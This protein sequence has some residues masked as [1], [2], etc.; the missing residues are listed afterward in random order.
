MAR[1]AEDIRAEEEGRCGR[2]EEE[3]EEENKEGKEEDRTGAR[4]AVAIH[5]WTEAAGRQCIGVGV[6]TAFTL[7][8]I[9]LVVMG[10]TG[11]EVAV[12]MRLRASLNCKDVVVGFAE[13][14]G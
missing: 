4:E 12:G 6:E 7:E 3:E 14:D 11:S 10:G 8:M 2:E 9:V 13:R 1:D 5:H